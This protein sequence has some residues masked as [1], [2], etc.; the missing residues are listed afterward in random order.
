MELC[1]PLVKKGGVF[2]ALKSHADEEMVHG[3]AAAPL[4]GMTKEVKIDYEIP[5]G[6]RR[7][8]IFYRKISDTSEKF[9][10]RYAEI[11]KQPLG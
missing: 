1:A 3:D 11:T 9:P 6:D 10:R 5:G 8:V 4:L 7:C 2:A